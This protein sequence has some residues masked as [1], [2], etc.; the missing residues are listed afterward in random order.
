MSPDLHRLIDGIIGSIN[1]SVL[2]QLNDEFARGQLFS[3]L[4]LLSELQLRADW[5]QGWLREHLAIH[6]AAFNAVRAAGPTATAGLPPPPFDALGDETSVPR[7]LAL[8]DAAD[9][10]LCDIQ[11][12]LDATPAGAPRDAV[13]QAVSQ[14]LKAQAALELRLTPKPAYSKVAK[15]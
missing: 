11:R 6:E 14:A 8:R 7:L 10:W 13:A 3:A 2:P 15:G 4:Y 1:E 5:G 9:R 12:W